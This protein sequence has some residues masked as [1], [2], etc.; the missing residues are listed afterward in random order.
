MSD[1]QIAMRAAKTN[2]IRAT[3]RFGAFAVLTLRTIE[4]IRA[5]R[6]TASEAA[7]HRALSFFSWFTAAS[8]HKTSPA[9][10][11]DEHVHQLAIIVAGLAQPVGPS[12]LLEVSSN[13]GSCVTYRQ[14]TPASVDQAGVTPMLSAIEYFAAVSV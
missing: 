8:C 14:P 7:R 5:G 13:S 12:H 10:P 2:R 11:G 1:L 4:K 6:M 3:R 9:H